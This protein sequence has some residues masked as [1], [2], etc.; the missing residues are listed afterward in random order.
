VRTLD[1]LVEA[2][3]IYTVD[4]SFSTAEAMAVDAGRVVALGR[5]TD[6]EAAFVFRRRLSLRGSFIYPG[7]MDPHCH[8][9][10]YGYVLGRARL[11][12][13]KSWEETVERMR[14]FGALSK[15]PWVLGRGWDQNRWLGAQ[16]PDNALLDAAFPSR[17]AVAFRIDG[18]AAIV[19]KA[20]LTA[21]RIDASTRIEGGAVILKEGRLT[22][23]LL[24]GAV[25]R[26]RET[27]PQP[28]ETAMRRALIGAQEK[29]LEVGLT[30]VSSA[31]TD[32]N[33]ALLM[34]QMLGEGTL[35]IGIYVMLMPTEANITRFT[36]HGPLVE[37][38]LSVRSFKTFA[39][40]AL[41]S[42]GAFLLEPYADDPGN[43]GL[44]TLKV[45][46]LDRVCAVAAARGFQV[47]SHAIGDAALRLVLDVYERHLKPGNSLRW[48]IEHAQLVHDD[49]LGRLGRLGIIPSVQTTHATSDMAWTEARLGYE[50]MPRSHRYRDLLL[51]NGWLANGSDFPIEDIDPLRGF[52][53]A[54]F[55]KDDERLPEQGYFP[56]QALSR[57]EALRAMTIWAAK[58][59]FEEE[60]R[61][62]LEPGKLADFTVLDTDLVEAGEEAIWNMRVVSTVLGG[63]IQY[64][65]N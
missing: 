33:E 48:R 59:N 15:E 8:F 23:L 54:V 56:D 31:G 17:P 2:S 44:Q 40:G 38:R 64:S 63:V 53:S 62:S 7:F 13:A 35:S 3:R 22:G 20:A 57:I 29:C 39:D 25:D 6:L 16:F 19:N 45:E 24:D 27:I 47:N 4:G 32:E 55:R 14:L 12:G 46:D 28:N 21:S 18:H 9:L 42:R 5:A 11:Y 41:G 61:G 26:V 1:L 58:A 52:R 51:Q 49:D 50:R 34:R 30:S 37:G 43:K 36:A 10:S 60:G 65:R